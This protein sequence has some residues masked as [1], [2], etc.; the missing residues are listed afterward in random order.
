LA[1][2]GDRNTELLGDVCSVKQFHHLEAV[3]GDEIS[4]HAA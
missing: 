1:S 4:R 3:D 2:V